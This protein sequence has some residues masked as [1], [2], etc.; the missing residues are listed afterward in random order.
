MEGREVS[1]LDEGA[2]LTR[3]QEHAQRLW[4]LAAR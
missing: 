3:L 2:V 4:Q 1:T